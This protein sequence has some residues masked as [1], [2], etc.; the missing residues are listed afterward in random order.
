M[1]GERIVEGLIGSRNG[2]FRVNETGCVMGFGDL[3]KRHL[4]HVKIAFDAV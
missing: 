2:T 4:L 3:S 1:H